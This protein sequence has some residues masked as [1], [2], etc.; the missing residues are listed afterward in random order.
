MNALKHANPTNID[1]EIRFSPSQDI[2]I[3]VSDDGKG[4]D[5]EI[6][7]DHTHQDNT[8]FGMFTM[9][10]RLQEIKG[11]L[12]IASTLSQGTTATIEVPMHA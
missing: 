8:G 11:T 6:L 5:T 4:F 2:L 1:I 12:T 7:H 10:E 9:K 3:S